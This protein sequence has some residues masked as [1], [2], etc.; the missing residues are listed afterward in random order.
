MD[1]STLENS[2][3]SIGMLIY[4]VQDE[5]DRSLFRGL[6]MTACDVGAIT[7]PWPIQQ[8]IAKLV[9]QEFFNQVSIEKR[10]FTLEKQIPRNIV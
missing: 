4:F 9:T 3:I 7:K 2:F 10:D 8:K 1:I 5:N 6:M